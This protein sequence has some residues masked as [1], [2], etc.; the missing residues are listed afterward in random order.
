[1]GPTKQIGEQVGQ[2][3]SCLRLVDPTK[4]PVRLGKV[5][6]FITRYHVRMVTRPAAC[7]P[8]NRLK[9]TASRK[10]ARKSFSV[11][12][13]FDHR[14]D[15]R[16]QLGHNELGAP[17]KLDPHQRKARPHGDI[18]DNWV[19]ESVDSLGLAGAPESDRPANASDRSD[20]DDGQTHSI[21]RDRQGAAAARPHRNRPM[22]I[23]PRRTRDSAWSA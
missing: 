4:H 18:D 23:N 22:G 13:S 5:A 20:L 8:G 19:L 12:L 17:M 15:R 14:S 7:W 9:T 21:R 6:G 10:P 16:R 11:G 2:E 1:M 3:C